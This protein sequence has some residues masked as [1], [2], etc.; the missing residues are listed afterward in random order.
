M[1]AFRPGMLSHSC[2]SNTAR[3]YRL[4][5]RAQTRSGLIDGLTDSPLN[6]SAQSGD[7][8]GVKRKRKVP[9]ARPQVDLDR[10]WTFPSQKVQASA[11]H[12]GVAEYFFVTDLALFA[13]S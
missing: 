6:Q 2:I 8:S 5:L 13:P 9:N 7:M 11:T 12:A 3:S 4:V 1:L 10:P